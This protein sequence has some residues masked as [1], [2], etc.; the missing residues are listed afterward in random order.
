MS[1][2][3]EINYFLTLIILIDTHLSIS[4]MSLYNLDNNHT[5]GT[6]ILQSVNIVY[7]ATLA[8]GLINSSGTHTPYGC[9][10]IDD[11]TNKLTIQPPAQD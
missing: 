4:S 2:D 10:Q 3:F 9:F 1:V 5:F 6:N 7:V 8:N 11:C